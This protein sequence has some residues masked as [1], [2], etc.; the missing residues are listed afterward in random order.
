MTQL[1]EHLQERFAQHE[2]RNPWRKEGWEKFL[3]HGLPTKKTEGFQYLSLRDCLNAPFT[4]PSETLPQTQP[5][6]A[7]LVFVDGRY[8]PSLSDRTGIPEEVVILSLEEALKTHPH[9]LQTHLTKL[10]K[11]ET[12]PFALLNLS[13]H[14]GG[15]FVYFPPHVVLEAPLQCLFLSH[16]DAPQVILPR[17]HLVL[18]K[19][20]QASLVTT[21]LDQ[22]PGVSHLFSPSIDCVLEESARLQLFNH[23]ESAPFGWSFKT[24]RA[25]LKK[26]AHLYSLSVTEGSK[27]K[28]TSYKVHL[29]GE[30]AEVELKG[31]SLLAG[32]RTAHTHVKVEHEAPHTRSMQ[33]FKGVLKDVSQSSFEGKIFVR[34]E[35]QKT[36]AYQLN[37]HLILSPGAVANS[38]PGLE[39]FADDVK[40][41]H[42]ATISQIAPEPLFYLKSRGIDSDVAQQL[43]VRAFCR[44]V[45][46]GI[47]YAHIQDAIEMFMEE[48]I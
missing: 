28:R 14:E 32:N 36:E 25:T 1:L 26:N 44:E 13:L 40:A 35:A 21:A 3:S 10:L 23:T 33:L 38:K 20:S 27:I 45:V 34:E 4:V 30:N 12:D 11:E 16:S 5:H 9:F 6:A 2:N 22:S 29:K 48:K 7:H 43:L 24:V 17:L 18:G 46:E 31:L 19:Y 8:V 39:I 15:A 42:G 37:N 41:S 47:S